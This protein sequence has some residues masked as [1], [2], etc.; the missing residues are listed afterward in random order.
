MVLGDGK[1]HE[2]AARKVVD[3]VYQGR[4]KLNALKFVCEAVRTAAQHMKVGE[5]RKGCYPLP[6]ADCHPMVVLLLLFR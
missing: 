2:E 5:S 1:G 4:S 3:R 6:T